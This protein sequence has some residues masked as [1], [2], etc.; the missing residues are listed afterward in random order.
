MSAGWGKRA[1]HMVM[2]YFPSANLHWL[3]LPL[4][5]LVPL[6]LFTFCPLVLQLIA[7]NGSQTLCAS[8]FYPLCGIHVWRLSGRKGAET[9]TWTKLEASLERNASWGHS[10]LLK[11]FRT[12]R[13]CVLCLCAEMPPTMTGCSD[14]LW[15]MWKKTQDLVRNY[16]VSGNAAGLEE[17]TEIWVQ[18]FAAVTCLL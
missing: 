4:L 1:F 12:R 6:D 10:I 9:W 15:L 2:P 5:L 17:M 8:L 11:S 13:L 18:F 3:I 14:W 7:L 16:W